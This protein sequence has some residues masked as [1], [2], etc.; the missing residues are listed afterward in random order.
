MKTENKTLLYPAIFHQED[1]GKYSV[2][3]LDIECATCGDSLENAFSMAKEALSLFFD[4]QQIINPSPITKVKAKEGD[5]VIPIELELSDDV[6]YFK[7]SK[8]AALIENGLSTKG[9]TKYQMAVIL[10]VDRSYI[11]HIV[12]GERIPSVEMAKR[13]A[14]LLGFDWKEFFEN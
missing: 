6:E 7:K 11:T 4:N 9:Y 10:G 2:S 12:K 14:T 5:I 8:I 1:D 3:F 13:I